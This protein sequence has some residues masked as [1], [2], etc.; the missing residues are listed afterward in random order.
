MLIV[1]TSIINI[2]HHIKSQ[3][4]SYKIFSDITLFLRPRLS[5]LVFQ[6]IEIHFINFK[7]SYSYV[8]IQIHITF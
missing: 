4:E 1:N 3:E 2:F 6:V 7:W 5:G 8:M